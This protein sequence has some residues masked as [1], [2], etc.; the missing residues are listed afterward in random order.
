MDRQTIERFQKKTANIVEEGFR[1]IRDGLMEAGRLLH[2]TA[3]ATKLHIEKESRV[4]V[5]HREFHRL[6]EE[7][8]RAIK[9]DQSTGQFKVNETMRDI[10]KRIES[11]EDDISRSDQL[12]KHLTVV[13]DQQKTK[14]AKKQ[15]ETA[16]EGGEEE[17][18]SRRVPRKVRH[19]H[20]VDPKK[21]S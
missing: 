12:L 15:D 17:G 21:G 11:A 18:E 8:Y 6:G 9:G 10:V 14:K 3:D 13:N 2:A 20:K 19:S 5:T 7:V 1:V 4:I 16:Q